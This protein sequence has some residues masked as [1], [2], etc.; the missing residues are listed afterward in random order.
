MTEP[1][2]LIIGA[3]RSGTTSLYY[4]LKQHPQVFMSAIKE[5]HYFAIETWQHLPTPAPELQAAPWK[6]CIHTWE[7]YL[8]LFAAARPGQAIGE[9]SPSYMRVAG[10]PELIHARLPAVK[11]IAILRQPAERAFSYYQLMR[12]NGVEP[13]TDFAAALDAERASVPLP[14]G[15]FRLYQTAGYY[16]Q[17]LSRYYRRFPREQIGVYLYDDLQTN[18][19][20]V[21]Q[22]IF[23]FL[24]VESRF[25]PDTTYRHNQSG[26]PKNKLLQQLLSGA[27]G[28]KRWVERV[29]PLAWQQRLRDA[30]KVRSTLDTTLHSRLTAEYRHDI[31]QLQDLIGRD[32]THWL[33]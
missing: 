1:T 7:A 32:L 27:P 3:G 5:T 29:A 2:F 33:A 15:T 18:A 11:I 13:L 17:Q 25:T 26:V 9:A 31:L 10:V 24:G 21:L 20:G 22:Q 6:D 23:A 14:D 4:Y 16:Y 19:V 28:L 30:S 8:A 12:R